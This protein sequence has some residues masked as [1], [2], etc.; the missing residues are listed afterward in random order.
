MDHL[1]GKEITLY[2]QYIG[3]C[4]LL[5]RCSTRIDD[6]EFRSLIETALDDCLELFPGHFRVSRTPSSV[7]F[8]IT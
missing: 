3:V 1:K 6:P 4:A 7:I 8:E 5:A 2:I